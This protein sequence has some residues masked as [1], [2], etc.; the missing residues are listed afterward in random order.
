MKRILLAGAAAVA[1][2]CSTAA[3]AHVDVGISVGIPG[4]F[5][6]APGVVV[7]PPAYYPPPVYVAPPPPRVVVVPPPERIYTPVY[8]WR[9]PYRGYWRHHHWHGDHHWRGH[10]V[11]HGHG[12]DD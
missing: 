10:R 6:G 9:Y 2:M 3:M 11:Y 1:M 12:D 4:L 5:F 7:A 8:G